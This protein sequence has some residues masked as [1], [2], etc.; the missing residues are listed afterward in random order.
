VQGPVDIYFD[1]ERMGIEMKRCARCGEFKALS[2]FHKN[3]TRRHGL[4]VYCKHCRAVI[5][6]DH[7]ERVRGTRV[8]TLVWE[9]RHEWLL[10]L[11]SG[12]PCTDCGRVFPPEVMQ[13][14]H[15]PGV[16]KLGN[17][18]TDFRGRSRAKI[19]EEIPSAS[20]SARI[21]TRSGHS[22]E[23]VGQLVGLPWMSRVGTMESPRRSRSGDA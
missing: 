23:P 16:I 14:D 6:H 13:W 4:Q 11:K 15:V 8:R 1:I 9:R 2:E 7:Y 10:G 5:D 21:A 18:S 22:H 19:L 3:K 12:R 17:I 20:W